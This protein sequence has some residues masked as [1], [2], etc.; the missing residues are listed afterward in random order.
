M[1]MSIKIA[2]EFIKSLSKMI[3]ATMAAIILA[4]IM[5]K[6]PMPNNFSKN[7]VHIFSNDNLIVINILL[8]IF[9]EYNLWFSQMEIFSMQNIL[10]HV[11][12][13][14]YNSMM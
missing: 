5:I 14:I 1:S 9:K 8:L 6:F 12:S 13:T 10:E 7:Y 2:D 3:D 11:V 4:L